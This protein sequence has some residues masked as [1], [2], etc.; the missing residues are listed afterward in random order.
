MSTSTLKPQFVDACRHAPVNASAIR[1]SVAANINTEYTVHSLSTTRSGPT[2]IGTTGR[3]TGERNGQNRSDGSRGCELV[4]AQSESMATCD[5][6]PNANVIP[7]RVRFVFQARNA[8]AR[9]IG[10]AN[11]SEWRNTRPL[12]IRKN[13]CASGLSTK[14]GNWLAR[15]A[16]PISFADGSRRSRHA[17]YKKTGNATRRTCATMFIAD[18]LA[19]QHQ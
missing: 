12:G 7:L 13:K 11:G 10:R 2:H 9:T 3:C 19:Y 6:Y 17:T 15:K 18:S 16:I 5:R 14:S 1:Y 8:T 4:T